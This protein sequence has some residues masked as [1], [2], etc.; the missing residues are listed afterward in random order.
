MIR[1]WLLPGLLETGAIG[2]GVWAIRD[3]VVNLFIVKGPAG[4]LCLDAG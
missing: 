1:Q 3:G 4:L 2:D